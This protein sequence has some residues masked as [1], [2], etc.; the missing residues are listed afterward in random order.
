MPLSSEDH[1]VPVVCAYLQE[2]ILTKRSPPRQKIPARPFPFEWIRLFRDCPRRSE[3]R[4]RPI[5]NKG[6]RKLAVSKEGQHA[7]RG[8][9]GG[10]NGSDALLLWGDRGRRWLR[11]CC[12]CFAGQGKP[13]AATLLFCD[14]FPILLLL[15]PY[16]AP[17][18]SPLPMRL[19][20]EYSEL[21]YF[22]Y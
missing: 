18:L 13:E 7:G 14:T 1:G 20:H 6:R 9:G 19:L 12:C 21:E 5:Q 22:L 11:R 8:E 4:S 16:C 2:L 3:E 10:V 15:L 17:I